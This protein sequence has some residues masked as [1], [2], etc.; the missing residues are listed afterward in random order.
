M[1]RHPLD[2]AR[3]V[4]AQ[5]LAQGRLGLGRDEP[6]IEPQGID[7]ARIGH[8]HVEA[9]MRRRPGGAGKQDAL[10]LQ[11]LALVGEDLRQPVRPAF[12]QA[13]MQHDPHR[14]ASR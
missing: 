12:R 11:L 13:D 14:G 9:G 2:L 3:E 1:G 4:L 7:V 10:G 6:A 8:R 5:R